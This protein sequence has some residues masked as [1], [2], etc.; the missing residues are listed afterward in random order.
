MFIPLEYFFVCLSPFEHT[1]IVGG[2]KI[3]SRTYGLK[4][5]KKNFFFVIPLFHA[6]CVGGNLLF[7]LFEGSP[8]YLH[9]C[10]RSLSLCL[11]IPQRL[12]S[13]IF[14]FSIFFGILLPLPPW[15]MLQVP[16]SVYFTQKEDPAKITSL[17]SSG[18]QI[19]A[20]ATTAKK[21]CVC[22]EEENKEIFQIVCELVR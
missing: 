13:K 17:C 20:S 12:L 6:V 19:T 18:E 7:L 4:L 11:H 1:R 2:K 8:L 5:I 21:S 14:I 10:L 15:D 22:G 16:K 9:S 3:D